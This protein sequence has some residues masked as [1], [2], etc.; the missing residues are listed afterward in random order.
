MCRFHQAAQPVSLNMRIEERWDRQNTCSVR[1]RVR[2]RR[3][4]R[5]R[6]RI[7]V[8]LDILPLLSCCRVTAQVTMVS[9]FDL[10]TFWCRGRI[11]R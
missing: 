8:N 9:G 11:L 7:R 6:V 10:C 1:P 4:R 5:F 3:F 2:V